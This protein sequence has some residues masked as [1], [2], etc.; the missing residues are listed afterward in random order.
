M[1]KKRKRSSIVP[2]VPISKAARVSK[3]NTKN[4]SSGKETL[5]DWE[6]R[7]RKKGPRIAEELRKEGKKFDVKILASRKMVNGVDNVRLSGVKIGLDWK[8]AA[9]HELVEVATDFMSKA[10]IIG[11]LDPAL[12]A[13]LGSV[14]EEKGL[15]KYGIGEF[16]L[17]YGK[18]EQMY[19]VSNKDTRAKMLALGKSEEDFVKQVTVRGKPQSDPLPYAVKNII[20]HIGSSTDTLSVRELRASIDLL[21]KWV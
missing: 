18:F 15:Y 17:L 13:I 16:F 6:S 3:A 5:E 19:G 12:P 20:S 21:R 7:I 4:P 2:S 11:S 8:I 1:G 14:I 9:K 10:D